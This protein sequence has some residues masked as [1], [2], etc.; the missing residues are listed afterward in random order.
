MARLLSVLHKDRT[1]NSGLKHKYRMFH[2][3]MQKN[4]LMVKVVMHWHRL[5]REVEE[6]PFVE[7]LR[8]SGMPTCATWPRKQWGPGLALAT[9][10]E[11]MFS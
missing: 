2:T 5:A 1:R 6:S 11:S 4:F 3:N 7:I 10:L 8:I 9:G